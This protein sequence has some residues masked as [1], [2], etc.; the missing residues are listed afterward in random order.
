MQHF[1]TSMYRK[2]AFPTFTPPRS[3]REHADRLS[4]SLVNDAQFISLLNGFR[5]SGGL[6]RAPEVA[7]RC[8]A[9]G[10]ACLSSLAARLLQGELIS[11]E[12]DRQ[13]WIPFF[14]FNTLDMSTQFGLDRTLNE[15]GLNRGSLPLAQWF[16]CPNMRLDGR[17]PAEV[18]SF[19]FTAV[20][21][22]ARGSP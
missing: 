3:E 11:V 21:V 9:H 8:Q 5:S 18:M 10:D 14:Q 19:D 20:L 7:S 16:S 6:A 15:L 2:T 4:E 12:W 17:S 13:V 22:A 1:A